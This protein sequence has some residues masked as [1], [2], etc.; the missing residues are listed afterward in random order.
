MRQLSPT[1]LSEYLENPLGAD[2]KVR[3]WCSVPE[4]RYYTVSIWPESLAGV[5][6]VTPNIVRVVHAQ[7]ISKSNQQ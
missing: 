6:R 7:K 2:A 3:Q 1:Q 4:N 5:V